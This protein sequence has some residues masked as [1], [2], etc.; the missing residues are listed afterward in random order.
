MN[1][2]VV[3]DR[4][5]E[6]DALMQTLKEFLSVKQ[7]PANIDYL[8]SAEAF[9]DTYAPNKYDVIF[10]DIYM[11]GKTGIEAAQELINMG[12]GSSVPLIVFL[13]QSSE[14][15]AEALHVHAYDYLIKPV[16]REK[17]ARLM[18]DIVSKVGSVPQTKELV[19]TSDK[20]EYSLP[21][22]KIAAI[23]SEGHYLEIYTIMNQC[24]RTRMTFTDISDKLLEDSRFMTTLR[25][26][27]VNMDYIQ[28]LN[29]GICVL[30]NGLRLPINVKNSKKI[31][32]VW[33]T[34]M[35]NK[36]KYDTVERQRQNDY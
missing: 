22:D 7:I 20:V 9:L 18:E 21:Y 8:E 23:K 12:Y 2:A 6:A 1:I 16:D 30:E 29:T 28:D 10:M 14:H 26:I 32:Q 11:S 27:I 34:Y 35:F 33:H 25:G 3:D 31:A 36:I 24:Y 17:T 15:M 13:T 4:K 19:F 5:K